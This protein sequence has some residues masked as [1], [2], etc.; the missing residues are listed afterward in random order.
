VVPPARLL[1]SLHRRIGAAEFRQL[2]LVYTCRANPVLG[3]F[4]RKVYWDRY[5][6][7]QATRTTKCRD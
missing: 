4:I 7:G 1:K 6:A 3:D 5:A 2:L